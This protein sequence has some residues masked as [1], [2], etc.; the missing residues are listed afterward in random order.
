MPAPMM[1]PTPSAVS[2]KGPSVRFRLCPPSSLASS[3][4]MLIG[5][6]ANKG[7]P[8]QLLLLGDIPASGYYYQFGFTDIVGAQQSAS[9]QENSVIPYHAR[10]RP[11][12]TRTSR[13]GRPGR[14]SPNRARLFESDTAAEQT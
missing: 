2:W 8:M 3:S 6:L 5:F 4:N 7:L 13:R 11:A 9:L 14:Q 1:A 10:G 12:A